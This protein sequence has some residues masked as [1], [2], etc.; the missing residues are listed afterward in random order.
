MRDLLS[1]LPAPLPLMIL[2]AI[3]HLPSLYHL[4]QAWPTAAVIFERH[5]PRL[6]RLTLSYYPWELQKVLYFRLNLKTEGSRIIESLTN[7]VSKRR[8]MNANLPNDLSNA[9]ASFSFSAAR[10][11]LVT[12]HHIQ[13]SAHAF[14]ETHLSRIA[15][16]KSSYQLDLTYH[17]GSSYPERPPKSRPF[18]PANT[19]PPSWIEEQRVLLSLWRLQ[20]FADFFPVNTPSQSVYQP[21]EWQRSRDLNGFWAMLELWQIEELHDLE[22][23][24]REHTAGFKAFAD[25]S[26]LRYDGHQPVACPTSCPLEDIELYSRG[27]ADTYLQHQ[28]PVADFLETLQSQIDSPLYKCDLKP[29]WRLGFRFWDSKRMPFLELLIDTYSKNRRPWGIARQERF[30]IAAVNENRLPMDDMF[31]RPSTVMTNP[32]NMLEG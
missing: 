30:S 21:L 5:Y 3:E 23:Y 4:I 16:L 10:S 19:G 9:K 15:S 17:Y 20:L 1:T 28:S 26:T 24:L 7:F 29:F 27:Q 6:V 11:L 8:Y 12:A 13:E 22:D 25:F 31:T 18:D 32:L 14:L 2:E